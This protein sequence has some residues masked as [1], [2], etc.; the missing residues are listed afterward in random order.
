MN[1]TVKKAKEARAEAVKL[2]NTFTELQKEKAVIDASMK[3]VKE[4]L[5]A[6]A[7][8]HKS[9]FD[10]KD[11]LHLV[12]ADAYLKYSTSTVVKTGKD[13]NML[14][15]RRSFPDCVKMSLS[16]SAIKKLITDGDKRNRV[17]KHDV[18]LTLVQSFTIVTPK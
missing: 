5:E 18:D 14:K 4:K 12:G 17:T 11:N 10:E 1:T 9:D 16:T 13:F 8:A 3:Q 7:E 6:F 2:L 15:F